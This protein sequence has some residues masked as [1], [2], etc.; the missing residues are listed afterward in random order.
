ML[1]SIAPL[2]S[3][4][5]TNDSVSRAVIPMATNTTAKRSPPRVRAFSTM[6]A[7]SSIA[8][9]P[10]PEKMGSFCPRTNVFIPSMAEMPVSMKS[11]G[12]NRR[13]GFAGAP[14]IGRMASPTGAPSPSMGSPTPLNARPR[15][16]LPTTVLATSPLNVTSTC[17][18]GK[19][20][21]S[22]STWI[23]VTSSPASIT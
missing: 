17:A 6:Y 18:G 19:P 13:A 2:C 4:R 10:A 23:T 16:S 12:G 8:G 7:A 9:S 3:K 14:Q 15:S 22:S 20:N 5:W 1:L 21:V 11:D